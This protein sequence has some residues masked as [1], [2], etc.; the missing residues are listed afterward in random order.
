M[1]TTTV[2]GSL[3]LVETGEQRDVEIMTSSKQR[4]AGQARIFEA[5]LEAG[6][7]VEFAD[8]TFVNSERDLRLLSRRTVEGLDRLVHGLRV[9]VR[10]VDARR[11]EI[12]SP[13]TGTGFS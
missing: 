3:T 9:G 11:S 12:R 1:A 6:T 4:L 7:S 10:R 5:A 2:I 13:D 8:V